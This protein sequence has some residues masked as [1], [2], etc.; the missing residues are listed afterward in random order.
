MTR[1]LKF[2]LSLAL[3]GLAVVS[4]PA[5]ADTAITGITI[6]PGGARLTGSFPLGFRFT[7]NADLLVD[8]LGVYD[9]NQDGLLVS[10]EVGI[11][12]VSDT[13]L[14]TSTFI[15]SADTLDGIFRY[16]SIA[17]LTLLSGQD[18]VVAAQYNIADGDFY[19]AEASSYMAAGAITF[20]PATGAVYNSLVPPPF[21]YPDEVSPNRNGHFTANFKF[22]S[23]FVSSSAPEPGTLSLLALGFAGGM[24]LRRRGVG[25]KE[26]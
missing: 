9:H 17:P 14:L 7:A 26:A 8:S 3:L 12:R 5:Q 22:T 1:S 13:A 6:A 25:R 10:K 24:I 11:F 2:A 4:V 23:S 19:L 20:N 16:K 21:R 15:S 18:Y